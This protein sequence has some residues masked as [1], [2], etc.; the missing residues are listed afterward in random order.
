VLLKKWVDQ[1][2]L[3]DLDVMMN[4]VLTLLLK[5]DFLMLLKDALTSEMFSTKWDSQTKTSSPFPVL[6]LSVCATVIVLVSSVPGLLHL[7]I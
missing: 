6:T 3:G 4:V 2:A 5:E 1:F 7:L